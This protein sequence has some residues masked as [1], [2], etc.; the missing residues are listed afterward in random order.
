MS[1]ESQYKSFRYTLLKNANLSGIPYTIDFFE[2]TGIK[3]YKI[4]IRK[5]LVYIVELYDYK[6]FVFLKFHPKIHELNPDRYQITTMGLTH[7]EKRKLL[8][9]CC[10]IV[11]DEIDKQLKDDIIYAFFGQ[12]YDKDNQQNRLFAKRFN[13]Y[14]KQVT[15]FFSIEHF[16]HFKFEPINLY[17]LSTIQNNEF[18]SLILDLLQTLSEN[19]DFVAQFMTKR[20]IDEYLNFE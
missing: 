3:Q 16:K 11:L 10:L 14:E 20:A 5:K 13:L 4:S 12:W 8:N 7:S 17:C 1:S 6:G 9:T 15:T 19:Q 18:E 2:A